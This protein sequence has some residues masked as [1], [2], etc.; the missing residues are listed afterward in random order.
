MK[1]GAAG[2]QTASADPNGAPPE[3]LNFDASFESGNLADVK[4]VSSVPLEYDLHIRPDTLNARHRV[5]FFFSVNNVRRNQKVLFNIIGYSKTKSLFRDGM[6]PVVSSSRRPYW[7]RMPQ[8][9]VYYYRSPRHDR[10]YVLSFP[11]CF[12]RADETYYFAYSYP[13]TYTYLQRYLHSLDI[14]QMPY[15]RR[16]C[17]GRTVQD[18]RL[19]LITITSPANMALDAAVTSEN[20]DPAAAGGQPRPVFVISSRVHPG[21]S[22]ASLLMHGLLAFLTSSHPRAVALRERAIIKLVPMLNPDG[23]FLGNYRCNSLGLDLNRLWHTSSSAVAPTIHRVRDM[24]LQYHKHPTCRLNL[25]VDVHAH[26][27]CM[28]G[29]IFANV[30][31]DPRHFEAVAAFPKALAN[32]SPTFAFSGTKYCADPSKAGTGRRALAELLP[33]VHCY[34]LE[35]SFFCS[36]QGNVRGEAY[37]PTSYTDMG[38]STGLAL[39]EYC[40]GLDCNEPSA[41]APAQTPSA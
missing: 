15:Y 1:T 6:A 23:V 14:K 7:E 41:P 31:E 24:L 20:V 12:E 11:F 26:S 29:F 10:Q 40:L 3:P 21:E 18:R 13:Y 5:W 25:F 22:P 30:P 34:T 17:I 35:V 8:S 28:N 2:H 19:D 36:M 9:A 38:Q 33:Q 27:T 4:L 37:T 32:H 39:H 16:E